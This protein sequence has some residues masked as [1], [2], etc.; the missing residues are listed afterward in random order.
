MNMGC[1]STYL[2][3]L[4]FLSTMCYNFQNISFVIL[5]LNLYFINFYA[6][7]NEIVSLI[8]FSL[9]KCIE[10]Q[11]IFVHQFY[12]LQPCWIHLLVIT[13][14]LVDSLG[15]S[16]QDHVIC[17]DSFASAFLTQIFH[18][19][20][21]LPGLDPPVQCWLTARAEPCLVPD[22]RGKNIRCFTIWYNINY[23]FFIDAIY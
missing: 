7:I 18:F 5:L 15:F 11:L 6:I 12:I 8:S 9:C 4:Y 3:L 14:F 23:E 21:Q 16:I 19:L 17:R 10:I 1:L 22:L 2:G 13:V 20:S